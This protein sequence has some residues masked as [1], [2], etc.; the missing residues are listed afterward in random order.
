VTC[1]PYADSAFSRP[2][3]AE[4]FRMWFRRAERCDLF[5]AA[6]TKRFFRSFRQC[7]HFSRG[8]PLLGRCQKFGWNSARF[9]IHILPP[10]F[11]SLS[12]DKFQN[13]RTSR[14]KISAVTVPIPLNSCSILARFGRRCRLP[15]HL[16]QSAVSD[17]QLPWRIQ[18]SRGLMVSQ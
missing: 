14:T 2:L 9:S 13:G 15:D 3:M 4:R 1:R 12:F 6:L 18:P 8:A 16:F 17:D 7:S 10:C 11:H 5:F